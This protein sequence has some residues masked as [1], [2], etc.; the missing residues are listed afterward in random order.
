MGVGCALHEGVKL[1]DD[2][3]W[4]DSFTKYL[5]PTTLDTP[6]IT[7]IILEYPEPSGPYGAW[8]VGEAGGDQWRRLLPT[9]WPMRPAYG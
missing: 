3:Q 4:T 8:G 5:L 9:R 1:K 6:R 2:G 7:P